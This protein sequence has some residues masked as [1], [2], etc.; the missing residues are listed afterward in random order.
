MLPLDQ[1][2]AQLL[3]RGAQLLVQLAAGEGD[4]ALKAALGPGVADSLTA[5]AAST[6]SN[7]LAL[8]V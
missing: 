4:V 1:G 3:G 8:S 6:T 2:D 7:S 5:P